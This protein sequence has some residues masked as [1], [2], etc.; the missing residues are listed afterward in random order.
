[1]KFH[2]MHTNKILRETF[3]LYLDIIQRPFILNSFF[4]TQRACWG[5]FLRRIS[6]HHVV[7]RGTDDPFRGIGDPLGWAVPKAGGCIQLELWGICW[8]YMPM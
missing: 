4:G 5:R 8:D 7:T 3:T 2:R 6:Q 1:M